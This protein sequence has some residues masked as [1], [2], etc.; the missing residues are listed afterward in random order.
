MIIGSGLGFV[1]ELV[2]GELEAPEL[3][4]TLEPCPELAT[5]EL[6]VKE[7]FVPELDAVELSTPEPLPPELSVLGESVVPDESPVLESGTLALGVLDSVGVDEPLV[8]VLPQ[9]TSPTTIIIQRIIAKNLF[10]L[11][12]LLL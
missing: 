10:I 12:S 11:Y 7:L 2:V 4:S 6:S 1:L 5:L 8:P 9:L 3:L